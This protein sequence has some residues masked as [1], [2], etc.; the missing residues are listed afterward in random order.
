MNVHSPETRL[1]LQLKSTYI[2][3]PLVTQ[4]ELIS[5]I[6]SLPNNKAAGISNITYEDIKHLHVD[7]YDF[8]IT[9]FNDILQTGYL[10][11]GWNNAY[12]YPIPKRM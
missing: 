2:F 11:D 8:I 10:P 6:S 4:A 9:F 5:T 12:L 3:I 7:F 1:L